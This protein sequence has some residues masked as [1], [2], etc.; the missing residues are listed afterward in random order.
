M[1][2]LKIR[3]KLKKNRDGIPESNHWSSSVKHWT[4]KLLK[5]T[6][7]QLQCVCVFVCVCVYACVCVCVFVC[8]CVCVCTKRQSVMIHQSTGCGTGYPLRS[9]SSRSSFWE[10]NTHYMVQW[11]WRITNVLIC[12]LCLSYP[13]LSWYT[14]LSKKRWNFVGSIGLL[15]DRGK[16]QIQAV[17]P[18]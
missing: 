15:P 6:I 13:I 1:N 5:R 4:N 18:K 11:C 12:E 17:K 16:E 9:C 8:V 3:K 10:W 14:P 7:T 2:W